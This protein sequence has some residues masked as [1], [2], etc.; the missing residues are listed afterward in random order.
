ME[1]DIIGLHKIWI[2]TEISDRCGIVKFCSD[3]IEVSPTAGHHIK[4][5]ANFLNWLRASDNG[6]ILES[7]EISN[8]Q[9]VC[10]HQTGSLNADFKTTIITEDNQRQIIYGQHRWHLIMEDGA[11]KVNRLT[12][13]IYPHPNR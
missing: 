13:K 11:W 2:A 6:S 8:R 7:I 5:K 3:D 10:G 12:W 9:V 1:K 4:G